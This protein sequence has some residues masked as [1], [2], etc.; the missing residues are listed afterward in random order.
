MAR[1][2]TEP[3]LAVWDAFSVNAVTSLL[4]RMTADS[5][6]PDTDLTVRLPDWAVGADTVGVW[7]EVAS[8]LTVT[9]AGLTSIAVAAT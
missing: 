8:K 9:L 5:I 3:S 2:T 6:K 7:S 1:R 4:S